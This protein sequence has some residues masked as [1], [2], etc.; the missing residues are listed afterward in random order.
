VGGGTAVN[1]GDGFHETC[2]SL[3][4]CQSGTYMGWQHAFA[5]GKICKLCG[6]MKN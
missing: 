1:P 3:T 4:H 6:C 2:A 5:G